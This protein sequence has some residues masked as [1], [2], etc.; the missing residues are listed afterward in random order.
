MPA[1]EESSSHYAKLLESCHSFGKDEG[2]A[3]FVCYD[4]CG[5]ASPVRN[6]TPGD[7]LFSGV[8]SIFLGIPSDT[9]TMQVLRDAMRADV[10][11][12]L[13]DPARSL[14]PGGDLMHRSMRL[15]LGECFAKL[16]GESCSDK[17]RVMYRGESKPTSLQRH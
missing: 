2:T 1:K 14:A 12:D 3:A 10:M 11:S 9:Q 6:C 13:V 16:R 4:T 15:M 17:L 7:A 5:A 8:L